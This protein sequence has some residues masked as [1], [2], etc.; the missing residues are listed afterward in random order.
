[1]RYPL[2]WVRGGRN[3]L[4]SQRIH[5][6]AHKALHNYCT[7]RNNSKAYCNFMKILNYSYFK[8]HSLNLKLYFIHTLLGLLFLKVFVLF[9]EDS[10]ILFIISVNFKVF[11]DSIKWIEKK[12]PVANTY[13]SHSHHT[14]EMLYIT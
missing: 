5:S 6:Y 7:C 9:Q 12:I 13:R 1:M 10:K 11:K 8:V 4:T 14:T 2:L 3:K